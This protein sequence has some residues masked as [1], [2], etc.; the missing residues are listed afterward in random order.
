[1]LDEAGSGSGRWG[2]LGKL[3]SGLGIFAFLTSFG[4]CSSDDAPEESAPVYPAV[5]WSDPPSCGSA[6]TTPVSMIPGPLHSDFD[7]ELA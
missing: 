2:T 1:M 7:A 3:V 5:E 4:G 6:A